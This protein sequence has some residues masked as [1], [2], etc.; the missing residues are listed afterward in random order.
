[1]DNCHFQGSDSF[2][3]LHQID[4]PKMSLPPL[5]N[6]NHQVSEP[7][8]PCCVQDFAGPSQ[9]KTSNLI[10]SPP[11]QKSV[12]KPLSVP[13]NLD[14]GV[15]LHE[16]F[17]EWRVTEP[18]DLS[19]PSAS[20]TITPKELKVIPNAVDAQELTLQIKNAIYSAQKDYSTT[21]STDSTDSTDL[22][23]SILPKFRNLIFGKKE[24]SSIVAH[25][26]TDEVVR[27]HSL[28]Y[29][30][31]KTEQP[32]FDNV[33]LAQP[34]EQVEPNVAETGNISD[35][36]KMPR[37]YSW[38][39]GT[40]TELTQV[41]EKTQEVKNQTGHI[42]RGSS[43]IR[44]MLHLDEPESSSSVSTSPAS[45]PPSSPKMGHNRKVSLEGLSA[46]REM[47]KKKMSPA[48]EVVPW[49]SVVTVEAT[50][51]PCRL[52]PTAS[53]LER[54][55]QTSIL[56]KGS[57]GTVRLAKK[58]GNQGGPEYVAIKQFRK[59]TS[60]ESTKDYMKQITAEFCISSALNHFH[61]VET[62]DLVNDGGRWCCVME[63][64]SQD[65]YGLICGGG[66]RTMEQIACY[67]GQILS[68][69]EYLHA[70]G[71]AHRDLKPENLLIDSTK[72]WVKITDFGVSS[73]FRT[74]GTALESKVKGTIGSEPYIPPE[75]WM[76][77]A[78]DASKADVWSCGVVLYTMLYQCVPWRHAKRG[79]KLFERFV[80]QRQKFKPIKSIPSSTV[81]LSMEGM[82]KLDYEERWSIS[83]VKQKWT[84][85]DVCQEGRICEHDHE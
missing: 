26:N 29:Q 34:C 82:L 72:R 19:T 57:N 36:H 15:A 41:V 28:L 46:F 52:K 50:T 3:L 56:G 22:L 18:N 44:K 84:R 35:L 68:G 78:Y 8:T 73:V 7:G 81:K 30:M 43:F 11:R 62:L 66:L 74:P 39:E 77:E 24:T 61:I 70:Q 12:L 5:P 59:K 4:K 79:D 65:L 67:F 55:K 33:P 75:G 48:S 49:T 42:R 37:T 40:E 64:L 51:T 71:V 20:G 53:F 58:T 54:Y 76:K 80:M 13:V 25:A 2:V 63:Y 16:S 32:D 45:T 14:V 1:M 6:A 27:K 69:V 31:F 23:D 47:F 60:E 9:T 21:D 83:Q 38:T 10:T 17:G 85:F